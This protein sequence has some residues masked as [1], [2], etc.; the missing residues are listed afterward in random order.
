MRWRNEAI[1]EFTPLLA[2]PRPA[3]A[4]W[5][6]YT[7]AATDPPEISALIFNGKSAAAE[8]DTCYDQGLSVVWN[9]LFRHTALIY[10]LELL[11]LVAF[12]ETHVP[13]SSGKLLLGLPGQ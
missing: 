2:P 8:L 5:L 6:I 7:D 4:D 9:Y 12:F 10:G 3:R 1:S 11:A 13:P